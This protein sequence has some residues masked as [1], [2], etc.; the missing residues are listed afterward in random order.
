MTSEPSLLFVLNSLTV[1]GSEIK[2]I[3]V[4]NALARSGTSQRVIEAAVKIRRREFR[5]WHREI[6]ESLTRFGTPQ[7]S[8]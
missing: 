3:K 2:I 1:G 4:A 6:Q 7:L 8:S 5:V